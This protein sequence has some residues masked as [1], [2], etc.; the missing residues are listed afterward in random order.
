MKNKIFTRALSLAVLF[1]MIGTTFASAVTFNDISDHWAKDYIIK[2][3]NNGIVTGYNDGTF[4]PENS[5]TV[6]ESLVMMSRL[7][8]IDDDI[9]DQIVE[10]YESVL[11]DM[12]NADDYSWAFSNLS[13]ALELGIVS[14]SGLETMFKDK[15]ISQDA[16]KEEICILLTK[17]MM[18]GDEAKNL[19]VYSLPFN[20]VASITTSARPYIY[21]MYDKSVVKGDTKEN[22]NPKDS[23]TRAVMATML[24][25]AYEYIND[26]NIE[27]DLTN[28][29]STTALSGTVTDVTEG[30]IESY[31]YIEDDN[32][33]TTIVRVNSSTKIYLNSK[34]TTISKIEK[35]MLV[36]CEIDEQRIAKTLNADNLTK[37]I[38]GT[39]S[40]VAYSL[41]AKITIIDE[42]DDKAIYDVPSENMKIYLDGK[43]TELKNLVVKDLI[44]LR[45]KDDVLY[46][47]DSISRIQTY[48]GKITAI[49]YTNLPIKL[50]MLTTNDAKS[51]IFEYSSDVEVTRNDEDSSLDQIRV[52]DLVTVTTEYD[53]MTLINT[54]AAEA[55]LSGTI[56]EI[57]IASQNKI[58]I[59]DSSGTINEYSVSSNVQ[60][61]IG[62]KNATIYDLRLGYQVSVNTSGDQI[63]TIE[64]S[65]IQTAKSFSGK[66][67]FVNSD[68]KLIMMQN[69]KDNGE[70]ELVYLSVSSSTKIF[71]TSGST[72]YFK[73]VI[74]GV[75]IMSTAISQDGEY[76]AV[77]IMIQ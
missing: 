60:I 49:D 59:A 7:Y 30:D 72:K 17:A 19:K 67:V 27:P 5:V 28:Y 50:T 57:L 10:E 51:M 42:D 26:E 64:A 62:S 32:D 18:L 68:D 36:E 31:I 75:S 56:K 48:E 71:D 12:S 25:R 29:K 13:I 3:A 73:D 40:Y 63:V 38:N 37:V 9:K 16:S 61:N 34:A 76:V 8:D 6:L 74:E 55:E 21:I 47:I 65:E 39:I 20:D 58:K 4:K 46:Q 45:I 24:D 70:T 44:S 66:V 2:V 77:S 43:E 22:I 35:G 33:D 69:I 41:P 15:S 11:E 52:G 14:Q 53:D 1:A 23:I 54:T